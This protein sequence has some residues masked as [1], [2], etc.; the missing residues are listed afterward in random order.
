MTHSLVISK[1]AAN[2]PQDN[3]ACAPFDSVDQRHGAAVF[4]KVVVVSD[5]GRCR[6]AAMANFNRW[7][8]GECINELS[9]H[10]GCPMMRAC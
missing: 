7:V 8:T 10:R 4:V 5:L 1:R 9:F 6:I 2:S 3:S